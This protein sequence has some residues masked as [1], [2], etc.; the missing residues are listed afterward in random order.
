LKYQTI[1]FDLFGTLVPYIGQEEFISSLYPLSKIFGI[2]IKLVKEF[3]ASEKGFYSAITEYKS[4]YER[5]KAFCDHIGVEDGNKLQAAIRSRLSTHVKWLK[6]YP[7]TIETLKNLKANNIRI[8]LVSDCSAEV[9][10]IWE[11]TSISNYIDVPLFS[12]IEK[13]NKSEIAIFELC[14]N[15]LNTVGEEIIYV[16]DSIG[17]LSFAK[18]LGMKPILMK[19]RKDVNWQGES[20]EETADI[21]NYIK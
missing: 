4:T 19:T 2:N 9:Y 11:T 18:K 14:C 7:T 17:E 8:G 20:I 13:M 6:P 3:W 10:E 5:V 1:I 15:R 21:L 12:C 16:G